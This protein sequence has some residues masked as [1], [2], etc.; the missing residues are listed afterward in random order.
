LIDTG[1][2]GPFNAI[3]PPGFTTW[4][5]LLQACADAAGTPPDLRWVPDAVLLAQGVAPWSDL[6]L[7]LP[8]EGPDAAEHAAFMAVPT[9][10]A[11]AAG[12]VCR[13]VAETVAD[14]LAWWRALPIERRAFVQ[15]GLAPEREAALLVAA[16]QA[17]QP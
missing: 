17:F 3:A 13:P 2:S 1:A 6:P 9:D 14:T 10:R 4:G 8:A 7:W 5:A 11:Q 16:S 15:T 12:L